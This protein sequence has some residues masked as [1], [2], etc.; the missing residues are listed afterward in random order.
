M[1]DTQDDTDHT[2]SSEIGL[3][4]LLICLGAFGV[5]TFLAGYPVLGW[6][7]M[8]GLIVMLVWMILTNPSKPGAK[9]EGGS[10]SVWIMGDGGGSD[11]GGGG[12]GGGDGGGAG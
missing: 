10:S 7:G 4:A 11:G 2:K 3:Y 1:S 9:G 5:V 6:I 12:A 8:V